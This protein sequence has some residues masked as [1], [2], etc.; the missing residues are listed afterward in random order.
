MHYLKRTAGILPLLAL[1]LV[2][3]REGR[4]PSERYAALWATNEYR[5]SSTGVVAFD[6]AGWSDGNRAK[7]R[8]FVK[9]HEGTSKKAAVFDCDGTI[10]NGDI[11]EGAMKG[12]RQLEGMYRWLIRN[13]KLVGVDYTRDI[14]GDYEAAT[15]KDP[16]TALTVP[17]R[18][19]RGLRQ[20]DVEAWSRDLWEREYRELIFP[21][22]KAAIRLLAENGFE[23]YIVSASPVEFVRPISKYVGVPVE[24]IIGI[25]QEVKDGVLTGKIVEPVTAA[26]GKVTAIRDV[27]KIRPLYAQGDGIDN[28]TPMLK[29]AIAAGG[30]G[31]FI[32]PKD[33][34]VKSKAAGYGFLVQVNPP[35]AEYYGK[36]HHVK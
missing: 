22:T 13:K 24:N 7:I 8:A 36:K 34:A 16:V 19:L 5:S 30:I 20:A 6:A 35:W 17:A 1:T 31:V 25:T 26:D 3:C 10:I 32:N 27:L 12:T 28:D 9:A 4:A 2:A 15:K 29:Y 18:S 23:V 14:Y 33:E 11:T 21:Q